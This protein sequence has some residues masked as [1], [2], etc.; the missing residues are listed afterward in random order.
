MKRRKLSRKASRRN[1]SRNAGS[2]PKNFRTMSRG[3]YRL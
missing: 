3:G 2:H 1:F